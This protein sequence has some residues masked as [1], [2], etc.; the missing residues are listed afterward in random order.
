MLPDK[1]I[2]QEQ[3]PER[4]PNQ[5]HRKEDHYLVRCPLLD[6]H[7]KL[8]Q[9]FGLKKE[10]H[11]SALALGSDGSRL[12]S[13]YFRAVR[14]RGNYSTSPSLPCKAGRRIVLLGMDV[15]EMR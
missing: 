8:G 12:E 10:Q 6:W 14:H 1:R 9:S 4:D 11:D 5:G 13:Y 7:Q 3:I 2:T 15:I